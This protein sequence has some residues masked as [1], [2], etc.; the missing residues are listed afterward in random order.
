MKSANELV[1]SIKS[2]N[3]FKNSRGRVLKVLTKLQISIQEIRHEILEADPYGGALINIKIEEAN[4]KRLLKIK[5]IENCMILFKAN[6]A[7]YFI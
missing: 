3:Y 4:K 6:H 5:E 2:G 7:E 1:R